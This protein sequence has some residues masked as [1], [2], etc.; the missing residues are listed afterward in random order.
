MKKILRILLFICLGCLRVAGQDIPLFSQ[1]LTNSFI[2]NPAMAGHTF[3]SATY[4]FRQNYS[5]VPGAP[6]SH[7]LS[8]HTPF[9]N[10]RMG[11]GINVFQEEVNFIRNTYVSIAGAYHLHFDRFNILSMGVSGE[12]NLTRLSGTSNTVTISPDPVY[13]QLQNGDPTYDFSFGVN[14]QSRHWKAGFALNRMATSWLKK[15]TSNLTNYYS[16]YV[17]GLIPVRN[18]EDLLEPYL[19]LRNFSETNDTYDI[20][21]Y[22]TYDAKIMAG[23]AVRKGNVFNVSLGYKFMKRFMVGYA[24][25]MIGS[26]IGGYVGSANE[27]TF[28]FDFNDE[29]YQDRFKTDYRSSKAYDRK[30]QRESARQTKKMLKELEAPKKKFKQRKTKP[31]E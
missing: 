9:A 15:E 19:A 26:S 18:G 31:V 4:S 7:L 14:Y 28:R 27:I 29:T 24:R 11:A 1:K 13:Y 2:Y 17:Q 16:A 8:A 30:T 25:E 6:R 12:Y 22:Y 10:Y 5:N 21:V 3:G 20:G 23:V